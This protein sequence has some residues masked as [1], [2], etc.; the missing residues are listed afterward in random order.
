MQKIKSKKRFS[1]LLFGYISL[2]LALAL[3]LGLVLSMFL[4]QKKEEQKWEKF[5]EKSS[6]FRFNAE[7]EKQVQNYQEQLA[8][9]PVIEPF[10]SKLTEDKQRISGLQE[11]V[12][13]YLLI[14]QISVAEPV[15]LGA[16]EKNLERGVAHVDGTALP[17]GA[18]E[19]RSV[20]AGHRSLP[21][22]LK[23]FRINELKAGEKIYL[24]LPDQTVYEYEVLQ[25]ELIE[26][27][28]WQALLPKEEK[29][30]LTLLTCDP[31]VPPFNY[32]LL[33]N[34]EKK[35]VH[36]LDEK[37]EK[38]KEEKKILLPSID[39]PQ[40]AVFEQKNRLLLL[41]AY[42]FSFAMLVCIFF[43]SRDFVKFFKE[44]KDLQ[45]SKKPASAITTLCLGRKA[46]LRFFSKKKMQKLFQKPKGAK[47]LPPKVAK[48]WRKKKIL[49]KKYFKGR[50]K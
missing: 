2:L 40:N 14:P 31:I 18:D 3:P 46:P 29:D 6:D 10:G 22:S 1:F 13:A 12:F 26:A 45:E 36:S 43:A 47:N 50:K 42:A 37:K 34:A 16:T 5:L 41:L 39:F 23:F 28:Q 32:R 49:R 27:T 8:N 35:R 33:V 7:Q 21:Q 19:K 9:L 24:V 44:E 20:I 4:H 48:S 17:L 11:D 25:Q 30:I 38:Q 15:Y